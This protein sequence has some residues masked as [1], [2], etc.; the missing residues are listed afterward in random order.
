MWRYQPTKNGKK[1]KVPYQPNGSKAETDNDSTWNAFYFCVKVHNT[2]N[3]DGIGFVF[4]AS[5]PYLGVDIDD[6][7]ADGQLKAWAIPIVAK[8]KPVSYAEISPSRTGIKFW[9]KAV[10][11]DR[12][13]VIPVQD[14]KLEIFDDVRYFTVTGIQG[15]GTPTTG[16]AVIDW[17]YDTY[18]IKAK[19]K[20]KNATSLT[21]PSTGTMN[22]PLIEQIRK[23]KVADKF[24]RLMAGNFDDYESHSHADW[25]FCLIIASYT[26][27]PY[28]IDGLMRQ[29]GLM[30]GKWDEVHWR[31][32][33]RY[34]ERTI[35]RAIESKSGTRRKRKEWLPRQVY[36]YKQSLSEKGLSFSQIL[37]NG[38]GWEILDI[39]C[40]CGTEG[41]LGT[42]NISRKRYT[43]ST[44]CKL[45]SLSSFLKSIK[46][47]T[48]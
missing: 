45:S 6:C 27:N 25:N 9:T 30:R 4:R 48:Q 34:G 35:Q 36:R 14:G 10:V 38:D 21:I 1:T 37:K 11:G 41:C 26:D 5:D 15:R 24:D 42:L 2:R 8:L 40:P 29:S 44:N 7:I 47:M 3:F 46:E 39:K 19:P 23:S 20:H 17:I 12:A 28:E 13:C 16:Q 43:T 31:D 32:G 18:D 33:A 22:L